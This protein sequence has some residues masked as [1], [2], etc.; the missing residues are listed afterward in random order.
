MGRCLLV[1]A[2]LVLFVVPTWAQSISVPQLLRAI[3]VRIEVKNTVTGDGG[4]C[5][6]FVYTLGSNAR[7]YV[8]TAKHCIEG[9][10]S[11]PLGPG[12]MPHSNLF[13][14]LTYANGGTGIVEGTAGAEINDAV[15]FRATYDRRPASWLDLCPPPLGY[16]RCL[17]Q[18]RFTGKEY[19]VLSLLSAAGGPTEISTG[20]VT[21]KPD[22]SYVLLLPAA[23]GTSGAPVLDAE[24]ATLVGIVVESPLIK[25][26]CAGYDTRIVLGQTIADGVHYL[27]KLDNASALGITKLDLPGVRR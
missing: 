27:M 12:S 21:S 26:S 2:V 10:S 15:L 7:A 9:L 6:G 24:D 11:V 20:K 8:P 19:A 5:T 17:V 3:E 14:R 1:A 13:I 25:G 4:L 23:C 18:A 22:G 16:L